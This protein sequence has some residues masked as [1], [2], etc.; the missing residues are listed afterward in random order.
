MLERQ[1]LFEAER[2]R[3]AE[4]QPAG[5]IHSPASIYR[6]LHLQDYS[7]M[8]W[9]QVSVIITSLNPHRP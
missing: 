9:W 3:H 8:A 1:E 4:H 5:T 2:D 6:E 7:L